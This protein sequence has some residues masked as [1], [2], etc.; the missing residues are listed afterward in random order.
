MGSMRS[1]ARYPLGAVL[2]FV[3]PTPGQAE[4]VSV[5]GPTAL[6]CLEA[7]QREVQPA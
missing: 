4:F 2:V 5:V 1:I 3:P 7:N 6:V